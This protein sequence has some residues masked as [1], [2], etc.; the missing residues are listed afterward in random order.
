MLI[1]NLVDNWYNMVDPL[2][3]SSID[4]LRSR[5]AWSPGKITRGSTLWKPYWLVK[6][7]CTWQGLYKNATKIQKWMFGTFWA[8][9][10]SQKW[11]FRMALI[12]G[13]S[14]ASA[15]SARI[16]VP[17]VF[18][19]QAR[20]QRGDPQKWTGA[21]ITDHSQVLGLFKVCHILFDGFFR[22]I[23]EVPLV[24]LGLAKYES[25][26]LVQK[27]LDWIK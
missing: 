2:S 22:L 19:A 3:W 23:W 24:P 13:M 6:I 5:W 9:F 1:D 17:C 21:K 10:S 15:E 4:Q 20:R 12:P 8:A 7:R 11:Y 25:I 27:P 18:G 14:P 26:L 16:W